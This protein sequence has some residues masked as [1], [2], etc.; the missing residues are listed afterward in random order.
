MTLHR[1]APAL[2]WGV[3][4]RIW[5]WVPNVL[6]GI[7]ALY[8]WQIEPRL[9]EVPDWWKQAGNVLF[10]HSPYI[11]VG[12]VF[13]AMVLAYDELWRSVRDD[14]RREK[15]EELLSAARDQGNIIRDMAAGNI[16]FRRHN[17]WVEQTQKL[18][19]DG[20]GKGPAQKFMS[21]DGLPLAFGDNSP[22]SEMSRS[23]GR[24][25]ARLNEVIDRLP[26]AKIRKGFDAKRW[27]CVFDEPPS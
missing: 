16:A 9:S 7:N 21:N 5:F 13:W 27:K 4:G 18:I 14:R 19:A 23:F 26:Q 11:F 22:A 8:Q 12:L 24:R 1:S 25:T 15:F 17:S 6:L 2:L 10:D 20:L 3:V